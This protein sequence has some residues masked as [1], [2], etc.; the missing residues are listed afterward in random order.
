[1]SEF[2]YK[3][4]LHSVGNYQVSG[5]PYVTASLTAPSSSAEPIV[6]TFPSVT[7]KIHIQN[8]NASYGVKIGF[9]RNGVKNSHYVLLQNQDAAGKNI[10]NIDLRVKTDK[11]YLLGSDAG[12]NTTDVNVYAELTSIT[13]YDLTSQYSGSA[14][15]G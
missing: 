15:I 10:Y 13:G 11:I 5:I 1:M 9:S 14:G 2:Q 4:S 3:A 12:N 8:L 6:V 7:Q